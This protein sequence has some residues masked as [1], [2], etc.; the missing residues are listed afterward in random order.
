MQLQ[1]FTC[2]CF[3][4]TNEC[5]FIEHRMFH[6]IDIEEWVC[7]FIRFYISNTLVS[8][9]YLYNTDINATLRATVVMLIIETRCYKNQNLGLWWWEGNGKSRSKF[10]SFVIFIWSE[11]EN[12][13]TDKII[14]DGQTIFLRYNTSSWY[15]F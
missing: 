15:L 3:S 13:D 4:N 8:N 12:T 14:I 6:I 9:I 11:K 2:I 1:V 5:V 10:V 7:C